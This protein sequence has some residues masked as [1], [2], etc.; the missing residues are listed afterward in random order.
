MRLT[1]GQETLNTIYFMNKLY[2]AL[3]SHSIFAVY[4]LL[5]YST[6]NTCTNLPP[7]L[8]LILRSNYVKNLK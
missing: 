3:L 7:P 4:I 1:K 6:G 5:V 8:H 2:F